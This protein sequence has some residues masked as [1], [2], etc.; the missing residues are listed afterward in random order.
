MQEEMCGR[1]IHRKLK[2]PSKE[3]TLILEREK[4]GGGGSA[5][6]ILESFFFFTLSRVAGIPGQSG[7]RSPWI[8]QM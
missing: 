5:L 4:S 1:N 3:V 6:P 8:P 7:T 2:P